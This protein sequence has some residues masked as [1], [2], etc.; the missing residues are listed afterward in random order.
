MD[1]KDPGWA[2]G[3]GWALILAVVV[4]VACGREAPPP[5]APRRVTILYTGGLE[6]VLEPCGCSPDH[7][8]GLARIATLVKAV[9]SET[10]AVV[11]VDAGD[12]LFRDTQL[13]EPLGVQLQ[14]KADFIQKAYGALGARVV[15]VGALDLVGGAAIAVERAQ[16]AVPV[17]A[18]L[19][20]AAHVGHHHGGEEEKSV[21]W[22]SWTVEAGGV[23]IAFVG[24]MDPATLP[25]GLGRV[26]HAEDPVVA[27]RARVAALREDAD[28]VVLLSTLDR[29]G[30]EALARQVKG[31]D[32][33]IGAG[34]T[35]KPRNV[36]IPEKI[37][38]SYVVQVKPRGEF[39]GRIDLAPYLVGRK[40]LHD[41]TPDGKVRGLPPEGAPTGEIPFGD[42]LGPRGESERPEPQPVEPIPAPEPGTLRHTVYAVSAQLSDDA[43]IQR[44]LSQYKLQVS[45]INRSM[46]MTAERLPTQGAHYVGEAA[47]RDCHKA[48]ADF[49]ATLPH[50]RAYATLERKQS[51]FDLECVGCHVTGWR[52]P[53]GFDHPAA[54]G[55]LKNVQCEACHGPGSD[56]VAQ[57]G[58]RG[59]GGVRGVVAT[60][61]CLGSAAPRPSWRESRRAWSR[62]AR[63]GPA[64]RGPTSGRF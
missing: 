2:R 60:Q 49:V 33:V 41:V 11:L 25:E 61:R 35:G 5:E 59:V 14:M 48:I 43:G 42:D 31:I 8:G 23:Q 21:A 52:K 9:R 20:P 24:V 55:N 15:N 46:P 29:P 50:A 51:E 63:P 40:P 32:V 62:A 7:L 53:G 58:G 56:H 4:T 34:S 18:N 13:T 22:P 64:R 45:E 1:R 10:D 16:R 19:F 47:C 28:V 27:V 36:V 57:G 54:V 38:G 37:G 3:G 39:V 44:L 30:N 26:F 17:S 6:G 12:R